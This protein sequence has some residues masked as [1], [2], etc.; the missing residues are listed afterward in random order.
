MLYAR[1]EYPESGW[2][3]DRDYVEKSGLEVGK[4]YLVE[5]VDMGQSYTSIFLDGFRRPFN[6]VHFEFEEEDYTPVDIYRDRR[7]NYYM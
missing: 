7:Y 6:S 2:P 1:F 3:S 4:R 5:K